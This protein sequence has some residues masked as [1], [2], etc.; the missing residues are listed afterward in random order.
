MNR[1]FERLEYAADNSLL[2][3]LL[4]GLPTALGAFIFAS[5]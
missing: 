3:T 5:L 4:V 2:L 1:L